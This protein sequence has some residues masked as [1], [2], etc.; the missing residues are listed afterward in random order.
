MEKGTTM[1][2]Q[3][4]APAPPVTAEQAA[5]NR[6]DLEDELPQVLNG[7]QIQPFT[8]LGAPAQAEQKAKSSDEYPSL[9]KA[10]TRPLNSL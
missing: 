5:Q 8:A 3:A 1:E 7:V 10:F 2:L 4:Q 6:E 9:E